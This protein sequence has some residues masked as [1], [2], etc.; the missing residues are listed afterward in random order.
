MELHCCISNKL[1]G[2]WI[3]P[4]GSMYCQPRPG[5]G[6]CRGCPTKQVKEAPSPI[7]S[8]LNESSIE[9]SA[10]SVSPWQRRAVSLGSSSTSSTCSCNA[11]RVILRSRPVTCDTRPESILI[12]TVNPCTV[13]WPHKREDAGTDFERSG[14]RAVV[15]C[16]CKKVFLMQTAAVFLMQTTSRP[17]EIPASI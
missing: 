10:R 11:E 14:S 6:I 16:K 15:D 5:Q 17:H 9:S 7:P 12:M 2:P 13:P 3:F 4:F 8:A 1:K